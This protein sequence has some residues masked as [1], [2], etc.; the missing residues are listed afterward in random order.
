MKIDETFLCETRWKYNNWS[1]CG[2][3]LNKKE[4][5]QAYVLLHFVVWLKQPIL[6]AEA[7]EELTWMV[8]QEIIDPGAGY[9]LL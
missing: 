2:V 4:K 6:S 3:Y 5:L 1:C 9:L 8:P 7:E